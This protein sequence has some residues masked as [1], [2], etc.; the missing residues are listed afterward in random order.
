MGNAG[1]RNYTISYGHW[2]GISCSCCASGRA[3]RS[4]RMKLKTYEV[5]FVD[6]STEVTTCVT[7][8]A[9]DEQSAIIE[10]RLDAT[11]FGAQGKV[12]SVREMPPVR[13]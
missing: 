5:T 12:L 13:L 6:P 2:T 11:K 9:P 8:N 3:K 7:V 1:L 10:A 4:K